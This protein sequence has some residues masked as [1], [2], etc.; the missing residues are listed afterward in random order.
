M[1]EIYLPTPPTEVQLA[2]DEVHIWCID[3]NQIEAI[4]LTRT[5]PTCKS[6]I[7]QAFD[8]MRLIR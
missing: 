6:H 2:D 7:R 5:G 4:R 3:L 8:L 1:K